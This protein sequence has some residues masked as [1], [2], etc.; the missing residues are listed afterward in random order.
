MH[1]LMDASFR[2]KDDALC[3]AVGG[4]DLV[5][6]EDGLEL[7][8]DIEPLCWHHLNE[9]FKACTFEQCPCKKTH[10]RER[11]LKNSDDDGY[12]NDDDDD[13]EDP[14]ET[15]ARRGRGKGAASPAGRGKGGGGKAKKSPRA[16]GANKAG[17]ITGPP[18]AVGQPATRGRAAKRAQGAVEEAAGEPR[19]PRT[20]CPRKK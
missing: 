16:K 9:A 1:T 18:P 5:R 7:D 20:V 15:A 12:D 10:E 2:D 13:E 14:E 4:L 6:G 17:K 3:H 8:G 11:W 19:Q